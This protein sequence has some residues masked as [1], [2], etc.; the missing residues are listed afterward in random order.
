MLS[1]LLVSSLAVP[2]IAQDVDE[3]RD[4]SPN[5]EVNIENVA[6]SV[7]VIGWDRAEIHVVG[8]LGRNV[9]RLDFEVDGN[10]TRIHVVLPRRVRNVR[11]TDLEIH[12][13]KGSH[14]DVETVSAYVDIRDVEG[15]LEAQT[16]S[17]DITIV[18]KPVA[19]RAQTV[20]GDIELDADTGELRLETVSGEV[21]VLRGH[22]EID[23]ASVSGDVEIRGSASFTRGD[24]SSVSG[25]VLFEGKIEGD[26]DFDFECHSG[27]IVLY[28]EDDVDAELEVSTFSG[29]IASE[30]GEVDRRR[31]RHA[32]GD[33]L[34]LTLGKGSA[35][36]TIDTFSGD[37]EI[38]KRS[39][40]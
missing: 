25:N 38:L 13:P 17:G 33:E 10:R 16:V 15:R 30:F 39:G 12:V 7:E 3:T 22:G 40:R 26:G 4:A 36:L 2:A 14:I 37:V 6:G 35:R 34:D 19:V 21:N 8:E 18:G 28:L 9:E 27:D 24:F 5:G 23:A 11:D 1:S 31:R 32:P 20:S 29:H